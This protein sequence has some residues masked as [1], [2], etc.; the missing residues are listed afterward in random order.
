MRA[1][2]HARCMRH[3][4]VATALVFAL[5]AAGC[6]APDAVPDAP[7]PRTPRSGGGPLVGGG[8]SIPP[9]FIDEPA[10]TPGARAEDDAAAPTVTLDGRAV[11]ATTLLVRETYRDHRGEW[12]RHSC[13][14]AVF[15]ITDGGSDPRRMRDA[16]AYVS[17]VRVETPDNR[18]W[19]TDRYESPATNDSPARVVFVTNVGGVGEFVAD[20]AARHCPAPEYGDKPYNIVLYAEEEGDVELFFEPR[21]RPAAP[22][23]RVFLDAAEAAPSAPE[24]SQGDGARAED[25][26][27]A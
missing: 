26:A 22:V 6:A 13:G 9:P 21:G 1:A 12:V 3:G 15:G 23:E 17:S 10:K 8:F 24:G 19:I 18:S 2:S 27:P 4:F 25:E 11:R 5:F 14:G 16:L 20:D 7:D